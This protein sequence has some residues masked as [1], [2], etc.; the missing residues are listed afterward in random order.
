LWPKGTIFDSFSCLKLIIFL[1]TITT[2]VFE[3]SYQA[4]T[5]ETKTNQMNIIPRFL[6]ISEKY[7]KI[8]FIIAS[9]YFQ[10]WNL[11]IIVLKE[12]M[13]LMMTTVIHL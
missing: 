4:K 1:Q 10:E 9:S 11:K 2:K 3:F 5:N 12:N 8:S 7:I 6:E 13:N